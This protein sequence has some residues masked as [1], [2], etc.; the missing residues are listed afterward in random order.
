[1]LEPERKAL[2][3]QNVL[4]KIN[5]RTLKSNCSPQPRLLKRTFLRHGK[6]SEE[7]EG[8]ESKMERFRASHLGF[9]ASDLG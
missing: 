2:L 1:M 4:E 5:K 7:F 8:L 3:L 6:L 9:R